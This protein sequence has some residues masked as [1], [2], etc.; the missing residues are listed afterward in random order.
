MTV[1]RKKKGTTQSKASN[2]STV[3]TRSPAPIFTGQKIGGAKP[4]SQVAPVRSL[5]SD[6]TDGNES[7]RPASDQQEKADDEKSSQGTT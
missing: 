6:S 3:P 1:R 2:S 7:S 5:L 4:L